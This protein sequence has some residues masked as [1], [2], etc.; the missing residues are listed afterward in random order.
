M[1]PEGPCREIAAWMRHKLHL[2]PV[3]KSCTL[4]NLGISGGKER[5]R[6]DCAPTLV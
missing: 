4:Y 1:V 6:S 3:W 2:P 5:P